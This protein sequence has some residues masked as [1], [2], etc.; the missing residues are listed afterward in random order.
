MININQTSENSKIYI[1]RNITNDEPVINNYV[2]ED[3]LQEQLKN[4]NIP[5]L[6][7]DHI[8][9]DD[10]TW[11]YGIV[12]GDFNK[13]YD[14][15]VNRKPQI[16]Y[17]P[18][19]QPKVFYI[20]TVFMYDTSTKK[21]WV[22]VSHHNAVDLD[23]TYYT[24]EIT[25]NLVT[26]SY[27]SR[28]VQEKL[29]S[30]ENIKTINGNDI[31]GSGDI[32]IESGT[33]IPYLLIKYEYPNNVIYG[34]FDGVVE[35][36]V[37]NKPYLIYTPYLDYANTYIQPTTVTYNKNTNTITANSF[38][39]SEVDRIQKL[40]YTISSNNVTSGNDILFV[41]PKLVSGENIKTINGN[42]ILGE[43]DIIIEGGNGNIV[44]LTQEEYNN[45]TPEPDTLYVISDAPAVDT[46]EFITES[47]LNSKG[48]TTSNSFKTINNQSIVGS[49]NINIEGG[50]GNIVEL[51]QSEYN[52]ITPEPD[53]LY[54]I[55]D[56]NINTSLKTINGESIIGEGDINIDVDLTGYAT[57]AY[58]DEQLG[59]INNVLEN[60]I[61]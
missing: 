45:T 14:A 41:Q 6:V 39:H 29:V 20:P 58:V 48:Y 57:T 30:G 7:I 8:K 43:G 17:V 42:D 5:Y 37:N 23:F 60:I 50:S 13:V 21:I 4:I 25:E 22:A 10:G 35:A 2:T 47:E 11:G 51:T 33:D 16:M 31:L 61:G 40:Y 15:I 32:V 19:Q 27:Q 49:G 36:I 1:Q 24:F 28:N 18:D 38:I 55:S 12:S 44:E 3:E 9:Y 54:L 52:S 46:S 56:S 34:D 59:N 26:Q 53:T